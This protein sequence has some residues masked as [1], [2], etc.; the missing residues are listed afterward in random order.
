MR[1][2]DIQ[3]SEITS[4][5]L[6][7]MKVMKEQN[8]TLATEFMVLAAELIEIKSKLML[9]RPK[10][11]GEPIDDT[12]PR[13]ALAERL[14]AYKECKR[15]SEILQ[16]QEEKM[17]GIFEKP[18]EDISEY[19]DHPDEY[20]SLGL[21]EFGRAF[22]AFLER[23]QRIEEVRRHYTMVEREKETTERRMIYIRDRFLNLEKKGI[24]KTSFRELVPHKDRYDVVISFVSLLQMMSDRYLDATQEKIYGDI[25]VT[26]GQRSLQK[27]EED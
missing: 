4:Q 13:L 27:G 2:S 16:K 22:R 25:T 1:I 14:K 9:P 24:S 3:V 17:A 26:R 7:Y 8:I 5:Y 11:E 20:L 19:T 6:A 23:K 21:E 18:Q 15:Q 10:L 12:D